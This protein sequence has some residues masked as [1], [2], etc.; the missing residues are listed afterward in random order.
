[1]SDEQ[2]YEE[3]DFSGIEMGAFD[4]V[5]RGPLGR[6]VTSSVKLFFS[7]ESPENIF[8]ERIGIYTAILNVSDDTYQTLI[9]N[10]RKLEHV[11]GKNALAYVCGYFFAIEGNEQKRLKKSTQILDKIMRESNDVNI[12][13]TVT[14]P[15]LIRYGRLW[16]SLLINN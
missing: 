3:Q 4:R 9:S 8:S 10:I 5:S 2:F 1:M 11:S 16:Q 15:D 12:R 7:K 6:T 13:G 14:Q